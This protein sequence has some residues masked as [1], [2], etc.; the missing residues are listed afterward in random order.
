MLKPNERF[1]IRLLHTKGH[2]IRQIHLITGH[3]R[4]SIRNVLR[5][6][7]MASIP[8]TEN[9]PHSSPDYGWFSSDPGAP[10]RQTRGRGSLL[11]PFCEY[12]R[13]KL[14]G[15]AV[16]VGTLLD[17]LRERGYT[18][19][20]RSLQRFLRAQRVKVGT[21]SGENFEWMRGVLQGAID[22]QQ[23]RAELSKMLSAADV[24]LLLECV[25]T[26][27]LKL[28]SRA[29]S[30][31]AFARGMTPGP[32]AEFLLLSR[33]TVREY[34]SQFRKGGVAWVLD[35]S[36]KEVKKVDDVSYAEAVFKIMHTP[37]SIFG[38]NR[39]TWRMDDLHATLAKQG[40][41]IAKTS[42]RQI[43][44][45]AGYKFYKARKVLTS[46]DPDYRKKLEHI[47][48]ILAN[49]KSD[50]KFFS[51]DEF[52]PFAV[53]AQGGVALAKADQIRTVPQYQKSKGRL[54]VTAAL[55]LSTNQVTHFYSE[56]KNTGEM[57]RMLDV[58]LAEY[59]GERRIF[60][61]WDA[62]SW[63]ASKAF[64]RRVELVNSFPYRTEHHT[65]E[66]ELAPLP[67]CA[68]FLNVIESV[69]SGMARAIIHNSDYQSVDACK[70]A[71]DRYFA[72]R[73]DHFRRHPQKA[74]K[75]IWGKE[76]VPAEFSA[77]NNCKDPRW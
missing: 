47:T 60:F 69:F 70:Q 4:K 5:E 25:I 49:L 32:I 11:R 27:P 46:N 30:I 12:L 50:E 59:K 36:R 28:R 13:Q 26:K 3:D 6:D 41:H 63:H 38:F 72:E 58:L 77:A 34:L 62:A 57:L 33:A 17:G 43:I 7:E 16:C 52:G 14:N 24:D 35:L 19:S 71:I 9:K 22:G 61:S 39:T 75:K 1:A 15:G 2:S 76:R 66:V 67:A 42:I 21:T 55:E 37:P 44:R 18:G 40:V 53:R 54:I 8:T 73:N 20:K 64:L 10:V 23:V 56:K 65:P 51:I 68:Q 74:G 29:L 31:L 48:C 45:K